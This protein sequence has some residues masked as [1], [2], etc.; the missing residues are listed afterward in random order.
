MYCC[1]CLARQPVLRGGLPALIV[2]DEAKSL[3]SLILVIAS[4][5][6]SLCLEKYCKEEKL[7]VQKMNTRLGLR[8]IT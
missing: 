3:Y 7:K 5:S 4:V 8:Q 2:R 6:V 1:S